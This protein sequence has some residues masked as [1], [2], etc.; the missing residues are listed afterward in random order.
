M[1]QR[2]NRTLLLSFVLYIV[3]ISV[4][5]PVLEGNSDS[6]AV[7]ES[8]DTDT[9]TFVRLKYRGARRHRGNWDTD[10]PRSDRNFIFQLRNQTNIVVSSEEK[11]VDINSSELF[12]YPFGYMLD[13]KRMKLT[14]AEAGNLRQYLL[15]GGFILVDD[16]HGKQAWK[17][18]YKQLKKVFPERE[19][20]DI[21][22]THPLFHCFYDIDE[23]MQI[24]GAGAARKGRT[25]ERGS[26]GGRTVRCL[27]VYDDNGRLMMMINF[28]TDLGDAWEHAAD[29]F[30]PRKYSDMAFKMGI[31][32]VIY[33]LTH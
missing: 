24:P 28:N 16:F 31:N 25:Y 7:R 8:S 6:T 17:Q 4:G 14:D 13:V 32:A 12:H 2:I 27:G 10:W 18:F 20:E 23:L 26:S 15:R 30:Y 5:T 29:S 22:I 19:P 11:V 33:S 9:F 1:P 21:P 3:S